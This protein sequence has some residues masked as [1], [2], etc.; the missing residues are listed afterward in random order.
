MFRKLVMGLVDRV[1][2][3]KPPS[4]SAPKAALT[5]KEVDFILN[6]LRTATF[7]GEEFEQFYNIWVKLTEM[8][9]K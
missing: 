7:L 1:Q 6:K 8:K 5:D 4:S 9:K 3:Q 2:A